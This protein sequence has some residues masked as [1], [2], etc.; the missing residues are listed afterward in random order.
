[1]ERGFMGW[2]DTCDHKSK[3]TDEKRGGGIN[4]KYIERA[5]RKHATLSQPKIEFHSDCGV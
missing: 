3:K 1:M 4:P 5:L 2:K